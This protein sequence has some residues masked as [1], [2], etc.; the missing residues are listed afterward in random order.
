MVT[1]FESIMLICFGISWPISLYKSIT[2]KSTKGKSVIFSFAIIIGYL[3][4]ITGKIVGGN[5]NYV[6]VLY[7]INLTFVSADLAFYFIN[8]RRENLTASNQQA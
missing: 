8:K 1:V 2:S 4:G 6:L 3:A 5:I 7:L